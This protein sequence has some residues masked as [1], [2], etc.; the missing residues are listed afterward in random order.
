MKYTIII[1]ENNKL[2]QISKL[3]FMN[4]GGFSVFSPYHNA[5]TG[6]LGKY[7]VDYTK[8]SFSLECINYKTYSAKN[9]A[10]LSF[11]G[12]GFIQFS[13]VVEGTIISGK[14][15]D[16][17]FKG[18]GIQRSTLKNILTT[19][20][21]C[22]M[23]I[24]GLDDYK[25][26]TKKRKKDTI[27]LAEQD[28]NYR[29]CDEEK[30]N[31]YVIEITQ[32]PKLLFKKIEYVRDNPTIILRHHNYEKPNTIFFHR[33]IPYKNNEYFLGILISKIKGK[34]KSKSGFVV[35]SPS[36]MLNERLGDCLIGVYPIDNNLIKN[37]TQS[38]D[39]QL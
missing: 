2:F 38:L 20:P 9:K 29:H 18:L 1:E 27:I 3:L 39:Y 35:H 13:S 25:L 19:G 10:K 4:C 28:M 21:I 5:N 15:E 7:R 30:W 26:F 12:D 8:K 16:G 6:L 34:F 32:F 33:V 36:E 17:S 11:H 14:K 24:W 31:A 37:I 23:T 22:S